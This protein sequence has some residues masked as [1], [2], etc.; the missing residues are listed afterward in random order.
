[1][2]PYCLIPPT[3]PN[4]EKVDVPEVWLRYT[5]KNHY[6]A[7]LNEDHPLLTQGSLKERGFTEENIELKQQKVES[8]VSSKTINKCGDCNFSFMSKKNT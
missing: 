2:A 3:K 1:M 4:G 8:E 6:D 7:L 5:N